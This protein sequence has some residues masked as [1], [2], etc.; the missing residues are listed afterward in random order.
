MTPPSAED[1]PRGS[2]IRLL[3]PGASNGVIAV[4]VMWV[5]QVPGH[6]F[7]LQGELEA[8]KPVDA[9]VQPPVIDVTVQP[10]SMVYK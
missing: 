10:G 3:A 2:L 1:L 4:T 9:A 6:S 5:Q 7:R 8:L